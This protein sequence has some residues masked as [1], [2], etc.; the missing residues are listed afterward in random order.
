MDNVIIPAIKQGLAQ[1]NKAQQSSD[2][3]QLRK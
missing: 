3:Q 1:Q 2:S